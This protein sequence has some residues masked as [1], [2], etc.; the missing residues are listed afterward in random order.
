M[1]VSPIITFK[2]GKCELDTSSKPYKVIPDPTP[3]YIYLYSE[4]ELIHFCWRE[5]SKPVTEEAELNLLMFPSDGHFEPYE[6]KTSDQPTSKTNGRIFALKFSSSSQRHLFWLQSKAQGRNGDPS[7][8]SP[9]DL[10]I[11]QIVD[12]LLQGEDINVEGEIA[13]VRGGNSGD[14]DGDETMEDVE[15]PGDASEH[16]RGGSGGAGPDATGGDVREE[17]SGAREGGADG[18]RA[19]SSGPQDAATVV[20]NFLNSLKGGVPQQQAQG[21]VYTTLPDLLPSST[22]IPAIDSASPAQI[23]NLLNYLPPTIL[24]IAQESAASIDGMVEPNAA[25]ATAAMEALS[26]D[27]KKSILKRVLRSPQFHQ[28]LGSLTMAIRDG[29]LPSIAEALGVGLQNGG[30]VKGG[31]VPLGGGDAVEAFVEGVKKTVE[32]N[33]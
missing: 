9:R 26:L 16:Q 25:T 1:S 11:G 17:G 10:K 7:W 18:G 27:Q 15:G 13:Q 21:Q 3:G 31:S 6:Y 5:R 24:L 29:G 8:F 2:A 30:L 23:D 28:S 32:Q 14:D 19:V 22:T 20:Q 33:K 4:D 12:T